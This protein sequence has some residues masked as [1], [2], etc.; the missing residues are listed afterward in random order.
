MWMRCDMAWIYDV[1]DELDT[2]VCFMICHSETM[3]CMYLY[4]GG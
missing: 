2:S 4:E 1:N 3:C